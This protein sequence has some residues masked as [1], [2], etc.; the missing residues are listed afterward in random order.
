MQVLHASSR[1][2]ERSGWSGI[3]HPLF[4]FPAPGCAHS[5]C[6]PVD[7]GW[8][9]WTRLAAFCASS[10]VLLRM[11]SVPKRYT[12]S[13]P[14]KAPCSERETRPQPPCLGPQA[15]PSVGEARAGH[16]STRPS[17]LCF[18]LRL[19]HVQSHRYINQWTCLHSAREDMGLQTS[20]MLVSVFKLIYSDCIWP[21]T[22][23]MACIRT[24]CILYPGYYYLRVVVATRQSP[25]PAG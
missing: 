13:G 1:V 24:S 18:D 16:E 17:Q 12:L 25:T 5:Y 8:L 2:L 7:R 11:T 10:K 21:A 9:D 20:L 22:A 4:A 15:S 3:R 14:Q 6:V 19:E 23:D